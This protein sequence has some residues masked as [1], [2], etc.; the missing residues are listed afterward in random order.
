MEHMIAVQYI[1][2]IVDN[3]WNHYLEHL[4]LNQ[5]EQ[6]IPKCVIKSVVVKVNYIHVIGMKNDK[7]IIYVLKIIKSIVVLRIE[8]NVVA[9]IKH[10]CI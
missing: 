3:H 9:P 5:A 6:S 2:I 8:P 4:Q 7:Q 10:M 1:H